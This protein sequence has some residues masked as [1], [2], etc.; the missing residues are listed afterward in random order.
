[1]TEVKPEIEAFRAMPERRR[2]GPRPNRWILVLPWWK[3]CRETNEGPIKDERLN[4]RRSQAL[5]PEERVHVR[6]RSTR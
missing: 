6:A 1:M 4:Q 3:S 5:V 2:S